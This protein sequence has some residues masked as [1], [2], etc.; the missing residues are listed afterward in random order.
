[1]CESD[2]AA[3][4]PRG[5]LPQSR[6]LVANLQ[7]ADDATMTEPASYNGIESLDHPV[8]AA[9]DLDAARATFER[10]GFTVPPRGSHVEWGTGNLCIMFPGD[11]LEVRG[12]IDAARF[13]MHLDEHLERYGE[14]LMGIAF[15]T[16]DAAASRKLALANGI[17]AGELRTLTRNFEHPEGWTH[18]TF[19]LYAPAAEDIKELMHVV[20][21][22]HR[23]PE[24]IR[25]VRFLD[26][27]NGCTGVNG[28]AGAVHDVVPCAERIRRL[29]GDAAVT[30]ST[31]GL[32]A[33]VPTGQFLDLLLPDAFI[34]R[35]GALPFPDDGHTPRLGAISLRV[36][37]LGA[38][39]ATL[40]E[41]GVEF[42][43]PSAHVLRIAPDDACGTLME[44]TESGID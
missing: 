7:H 8:I 3:N 21:L 12:I 10:L 22:E 24:L 43:Q 15:G 29:L 44:F 28:I 38:T 13:T 30:T 31:A 11:Y 36:A 37:D 18:P 25:P 27:A 9:T 41:H 17:D 39:A 4:R 16:S 19:T 40:R 5:G 42:A 35:F 26:H 14:G 34:T 20:V 33:Q 2:L 1:M 23:T 32:R 6:A